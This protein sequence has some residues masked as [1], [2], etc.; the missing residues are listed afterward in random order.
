MLGLAPLMECSLSLLQEQ[1]AHVSFSFSSHKLLSHHASLLLNRLSPKT[2]HT[3]DAISPRN[4]R[5]G[6]DFVAQALCEWL[7]QT[8]FIFFFKS[9]QL[10]IFGITTARKDCSPILT[11]TR[12]CCQN[13]PMNFFPSYTQDSFDST[14]LKG[15]VYLE[16]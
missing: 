14:F 8:L 4:A 12:V 7:C 10:C 3:S 13:C 5:P 11:Q 1:I 9:S 15:K 6:V 2:P 16:G